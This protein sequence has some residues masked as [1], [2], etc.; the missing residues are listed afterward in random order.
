MQK[1]FSPVL[2]V[3]ESQKLASDEHFTVDGTLIEVWASMKSF[4]KRDGS[5]SRLCCTNRPVQLPSF[6]AR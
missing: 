4:S 2:R 5:G 6:G 3:A 1:F